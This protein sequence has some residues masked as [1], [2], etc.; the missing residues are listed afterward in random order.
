[1]Q[2]DLQTH[3]ATL[4]TSVNQPEGLGALFV[5]N[6]QTTGNGDLFVSWGNT[7]YMSEYSQSGALL[8]NAQL[9]AGVFTYRAYLLPWPPVP[10][11]HDRVNEERSTPPSSPLGD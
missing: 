3:V 6:A 4:L 8:F 10:P 5:G 7:T 1:V 11:D 2:L 9:P